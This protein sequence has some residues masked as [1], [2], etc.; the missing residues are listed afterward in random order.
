[1]NMKELDRMGKIIDQIIT[2]IQKLEGWWLGNAIY[3]LHNIKQTFRN[4][5]NLSS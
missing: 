2:G 4:G 5:Y 3:V 1:M